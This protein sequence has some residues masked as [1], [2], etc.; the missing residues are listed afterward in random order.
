M[1]GRE[2]GCEIRWGKL[3]GSCSVSPLLPLGC[4]QKQDLCDRSAPGG[5]H[6]KLGRVAGDRTLAG[7]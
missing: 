5:G 1:R 7:C 3:V 4:F 6:E 2:V